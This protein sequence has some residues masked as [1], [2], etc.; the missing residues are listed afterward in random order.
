MVL[1]TQLADCVSTIYFG[2][3]MFALEKQ[4]ALLTLCERLFQLALFMVDNSYSF[5][6]QVYVRGLVTA[7]FSNNTSAS[8]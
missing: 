7:C 4:L 5:S 6:S 1:M 8:S 3:H 2:V